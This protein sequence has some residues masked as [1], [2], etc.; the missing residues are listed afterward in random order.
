MQAAIDELGFVRNEAARALRKGVAHTLGVVVEDISNPYFTDMARGAEAAL[1]TA[2]YDALWCTSDGSPEK[3]RRC[4]DFLEEQ[5]VSGIIITPVALDASRIARL[6]TRGMQVVLIDRRVPGA[7]SSS[8]SVDHVMG[9]SLAVR[10]L[11]AIGRTDI[12]FVTA[13]PEPPPL[14]QRRGGALRAL[15]RA[16]Y[17]PALTISMTESSAAAGQSAARRLLEFGTLPNGI[18]CA[19]DLMAIGLVNELTRNGVKIPQD[20]AVIGYDD[21]DLAATA[22][23]PLTTIHQPRRELGRKATELVLADADNQHI[24]LAPELVV[25]DSSE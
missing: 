22:V 10:H 4:L 14:R 21:I 25:R 20:C 23:V 19:N 1:N 13:E 11:V 7:G 16:G 8:V 17:P 15:A 12:A 24:V 18:F 9:G 3:E 6:R 2:G 5:G